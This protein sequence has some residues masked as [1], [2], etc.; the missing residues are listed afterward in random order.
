VKVKQTGIFLQQLTH[1]E[2]STQN[3]IDFRSIPHQEEAFEPIVDV[4]GPASNLL[5]AH[6]PTTLMTK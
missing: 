2:L 6:E 4:V 3:L 1:N 5:T